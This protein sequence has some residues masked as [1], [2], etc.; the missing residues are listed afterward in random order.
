MIEFL[1]WICLKV[2][3]RCCE[4][5]YLIKVILNCFLNWCCVVFVLMDNLLKFLFV[6][7]FFGFFLIV[8]ISNF[9]VGDNFVGLESGL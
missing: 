1:F 9:I 5:V 4:C 8:L 7:F 6:Y 2:R 3:L